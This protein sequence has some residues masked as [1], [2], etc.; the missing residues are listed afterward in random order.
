MLEAIC[1]SENYG[2]RGTKTDATEIVF[3]F[4]F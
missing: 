1:V 2:V 3:D 4:V